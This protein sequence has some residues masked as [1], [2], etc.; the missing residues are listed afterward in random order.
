MSSADYGIY[1]LGSTGKYMDNLTT[2][3][4]I[5]KFLNGTAVGVND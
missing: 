3:I 5:T 2:D 1:Y 4:A